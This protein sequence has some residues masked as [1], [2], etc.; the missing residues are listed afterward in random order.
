M[1]LSVHRVCI[2]CASRQVH[3]AWAANHPT[4][5][6]AAVTRQRGCAQGSKVTPKTHLT[7][8]G[9]VRSLRNKRNT[10]LDGGSRF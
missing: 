7:V 1:A 8:G 4:N 5:V 9:H 2:E 3:P 6:Q 10:L